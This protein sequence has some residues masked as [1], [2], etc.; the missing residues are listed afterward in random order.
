[1]DVL[2]IIIMLIGAVLL[3]TGL[4]LF[5]SGKR[6]E[7]S[8]SNV[9]GF[10]VK[11]NISNPSVLLIVFG[12]GLI[13]LPRFLPNQS[14]HIP[15]ETAASAPIGRGDSPGQ[16]PVIKDTPKPIPQPQ[17]KSNAAAQPAD[18]VVTE[19]AP[20]QPAVTSPSAFFP[21]GTWQ[22]DDYEEN[23]INLSGNIV[24]NI[25]FQQQNQSAT[26]WQANYQLTDIWGYV[27]NIYYNGTIV[28]NG[29][30]YT[31][32]VLQS[33]DPNFMGQSTANLDM[34]MEAGNRLH[35]EYVLNGSRTITHWVE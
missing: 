13:L 2:D 16:Q 19:A 23:G 6:S 22:L 10:G 21:T 4:A 32:Q 15:M 9:E 17:P 29:N 8:Q 26:S 3:V 1:M 33:N 24:G 20:S 25:N 7:H 27:S 35:M 31:L 28:A 18:N 14:Q 11:I 34:R 5:V 30:R 12:I